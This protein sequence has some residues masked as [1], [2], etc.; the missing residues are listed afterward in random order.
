MNNNLIQQIEI[1]NFRSIKS[2]KINCSEYN[3]FCGLNDVGKSNILKALNLFFNQETDFKTPFDFS[4]DYNKYA[5]AEAQT[6]KK[7]KQLIK[8]KVTFNK[9]KSYKSIPN[10]TFY[11]EKTFDRNDMT[12]TGSIKYSE[13]SAAARTAIS[14]LYNQIRYVYIPALKGKDVV[15]YLLGLLGEQQLIGSTQIEDLNKSINDTT[16]DLS[17]LLQQSN[18]AI[19]VSFGLPTLLSDFWQQLSVGTTYEYT[20]SLERELAK[21]KSNTIH[22]NPAAYQI[23]LTMRGDGIKSKFLPPIL[24]WL[25]NHNKQQFIWGIDEPENSLEFRAAEELSYLFGNKYALTSQIFATSHSMAFINPRRTDKIKPVIF[26]TIKANLGE[27]VLENITNLYSEQNREEL[28]N[29]IGVLAIQKELITTFRQKIEEKEK[30][31][32]V[33]EQAIND[34]KTKLTAITK[35]LVITE[36]QTDIIHIL[37]AKEKLGIADVEFDRIEPDCQP[38]GDCDLLELLKHISKVHHNHTII[39]IFDRD[40]I[41]IMK[42]IKEDG[43]SYKDYGNNVYAFCIPLP[44]NRKDKGQTKISIEYLYTDDEIKTELENGCRLFFG[45][46]FTRNSLRHNTDEDLTLRTLDGKGCDKIIENNG[47]QA[48]YD[49]DDNNILAK[50]IDFAEAIRDDKI[51][52]SDES[53]RNFQ[54]L[55][56][57]I[58]EICE[59]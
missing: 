12:G 42:K 32:K 15:Q 55:F 21:R 52:I 11:I 1:T 22:L 29:E 3:L 48:V 4:V 10:S 31:K 30:A 14:R 45:T 19:G 36:G 18:I 43:K 49:K 58:K 8:I 16:K 7:K 38:S 6:S 24:T 46:E 35:P 20:T 40:N 28:L 53:W 34:I 39:G 54:P 13:E 59:K 57:T 41:D 51:T 27:T 33:L 2:A 50:K 23:P 17:E 9:P 44:Q 37:K 47:K 25:Q 56:D 5:L 26:K